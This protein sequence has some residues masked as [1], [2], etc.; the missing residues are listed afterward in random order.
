MFCILLP[1]V[2]PIIQQN[3]IR[4]I[5]DAGHG[6]PDGGA[7]GADGTTEQ[8]LNLQISQ[9]LFAVLPKEQSLMTRSDEHGLAEGGGS[10]RDKKIADMKSRVEIANR[11]S[12]ALWISLHMNT[13]PN[14]SVYGCQVFYRK[15]DERSMQVAQRLQDS[16]NKH[17][18]PNH[19]KQI[20]PIPEKLYLFKNT[21]NSAILI[22]CGFITNIDELDKLKND[23]YQKQLAQL[24]SEAVTQ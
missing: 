7:V 3:S 18:Q 12:N 23:T 2:K 13:Y 8:I 16:I 9:K 4:Y 5:I 17:L 20:K 14:G 22:E 15:N 11:H 10:I 6:L 19:T 24:I 1:S 21:K